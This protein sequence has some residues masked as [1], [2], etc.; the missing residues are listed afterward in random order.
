[1]AKQQLTVSDAEYAK[2]WLDFAAL[3]N[4]LTGQ[5]A[6]NSPDMA[7]LTSSARHGQHNQSPR[8]E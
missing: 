4:G 5:G 3:D 8:T 1:M 2:L 7:L 6:T